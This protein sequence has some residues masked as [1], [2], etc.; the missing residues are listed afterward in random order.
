MNGALHAQHDMSSGSEVFVTV[1]LCLHA[2]A[3]AL[4]PFRSQSTSGLCQHHEDGARCRQQRRKDGERTAY[5][6]STYTQFGQ[7]CP[8]EEVASLRLPSVI[9]NGRVRDFDRYHR[10]EMSRVCAP[11]RQ[12]LMRTGHSENP[13]RR[14]ADV[15]PIRVFST[16]VYG[17]ACN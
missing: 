12:L 10:Y 6:Q 14:E 7:G 17:S 5:G 16:V 2:S 9:R 15:R 1:R 4:L 13:G 11:I 8:S 3:A